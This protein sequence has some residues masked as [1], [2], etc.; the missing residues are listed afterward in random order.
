[1]QNSDK[2]LEQHEYKRAREKQQVVKRGNLEQFLKRIAPFYT[3]M[4]E[5]S[6]YIELLFYC[7]LISSCS[8]FKNKVAGFVNT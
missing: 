4:N 3:H 8:V 5:I 2:P 1:M 7:A 6:V